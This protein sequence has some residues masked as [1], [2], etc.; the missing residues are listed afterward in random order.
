MWNKPESRLFVALGFFAIVILLVASCIYAFRLPLV[1]Q[2]QGAW[3][4]HT[5]DVLGQLNALSLHIEQQ[6]VAPIRDDIDRLQRLTADNPRQQ[7][8]FPLLRVSV[9][10]RVG[11]PAG[12]TR[13]QD[14]GDQNIR[15]QIETLRKEEEGLLESRLDAW[16]RAATRT[17]GVFLAG[18]AALLLLVSAVCAALNRASREHRERALAQER[19]ALVQKAQ[20]ARLTTIVEIQRDVAGHSLKLQ[21]ALRVIADRVR[22][23]T[24]ADGGIVE[25]MEGTEM[26]YRAA[27]GTASPYVGLRLNAAGSLSGLC[28]EKNQI[29]TCTDSETDDRVDREACRKVG[30]RSMIVVPLR[31]EG[32]PVGVLKVVSSQ[33]DA[34]GSD[35]QAALE[36]MAGL[37]S[38]TLSDASEADSLQTANQRLS[39]K[40][41]ELEQLATT[42][43]LTGIANRRSFQSALETGFQQARRNGKPLSLVLLDVDHFKKFNDAFG[44]PAGDAVLKRVAAIL[45]EN[46]RANDCAARYG[47]EEFA[48][49]L[50]DASAAAGLNIAERVRQAIAAATWEHRQITISVGVSS[51]SPQIEDASALL[52]AADDALYL[53]KS[54]GRDRVSVGPLP[55]S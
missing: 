18:T 8:R 36:L 53:S 19:L 6:G 1:Q 29:L 9:A 44:H 47:G 15:A 14:I 5:Y 51:L 26:V 38:A 33:T 24:Q 27:S 46:A 41:H 43:G 32:Q 13:D 21:D 17:R 54:S 52:K 30:L 3:V 31:H 4:A 22:S 40:T 50:P 37:L 11:S 7:A 39:E 55:A 48:L 25:M 16:N 10:D 12:G 20:A 49:L 45:Q 23:L 2:E 35:D 34:F 42:D 28:L